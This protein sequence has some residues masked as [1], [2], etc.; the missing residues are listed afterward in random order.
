MKSYSLVNRRRI[1]RDP[2][3]LAYLYPNMPVGRF[4]QAVD[5]YYRNVTV[6]T[7]EDVVHMVGLKLVP[8][9][10]VHHKRREADKRIHILGRTY[11]VR[12]PADLTPLEMEK[13][14]AICAGELIE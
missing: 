11:Y 6:K 7:I 13:Y 1:E 2:R 3:K 9:S 4:K 8:A 10:C 14:R 5:D 12:D